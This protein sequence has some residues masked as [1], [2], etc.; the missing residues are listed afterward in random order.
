[1]AAV[2]VQVKLEEP[3]QI[4]RGEEIA[5]RGLDDAV[6]ED[7]VDAILDLGAVVDQGGALGGMAAGLSIFVG[8]PD[9]GQEVQAE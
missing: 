6:V 1:M 8:D 5:G 2:G 9:A 7:A 4:G 3:L